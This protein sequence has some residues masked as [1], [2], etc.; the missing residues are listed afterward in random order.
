MIINVE[1]PGFRRATAVHL[2]ICVVLI[3][4]GVFGMVALT[5]LREAPAEISYQEASLKVQTVTA[6]PEDI[7]ICIVG[8]GEVTPLDV[9]S[10][11]PEIAGKIV[12]VHPRLEPGEVI[13]KGDILFKIDPRN[14]EAVCK[15]ARAKVEQCKNAIS[16]LQIQQA[17]DLERLKT[18]ERNRELARLQLDR[19]HELFGTHGVVAQAQVESAELAFNSA[20]DLADQLARAVELYPIQIKDAQDS[21]A[22][23]QAESQ[24]A[25]ANLERCVVRAPF[26]A[27]VKNASLET[28]QYVSPGSEVLTLAD[29]SILEI[30]APLDSRDAQKWLRFAGDDSQGKTT[31][32]NGLER[33]PCRIRWTEAPESHVWKGR[34]HRV[35]NFE[36]QT[37]TLTV[38]VRIEADSLVSDHS[39]G[40]P[41]VEGMFCSVEIPGK[42]LKGGFQ[43]PT[44]AVSF[45]DTVYVARNS[46]LKTVPVSV[47]RRQG[48]RTLVSAGLEEGDIVITTRLVDPIE[49]TLLE[50]SF[51]ESTSGESTSMESGERP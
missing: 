6:K 17:V 19:A 10:I 50:I 27:R 2:V 42:I 32:F 3:L 13:A 44:S 29:D 40:L 41:L 48:E 47:A 16:Q 37:R 49:N 15:Q 4:V 34:L 33:V 12:S 31:W 14:Y 26:D 39:Q 24:I 45:E 36:R 25:E 8:Y 21:L 30:H 9:V 51:G 11:I 23:A 7:Q 35:V 22:S 38:A 5:S 20:A 18:L 1:I 46:R 43:L 28:G